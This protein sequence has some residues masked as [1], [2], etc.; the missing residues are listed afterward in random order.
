[1]LFWGMAKSSYGVSHN[2]TKQKNG[3]KI[4]Y[5][6]IHSGPLR[7]VY[8]HRLVAEALLRRRLKDNETVDHEDQ[9]SL[10]PDPPNIQV[11]S[12]KDHGK[13][14]R[15]REGRRKQKKLEGVEG[16]D[17]EIIFRGRDVFNER[18]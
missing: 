6:R 13:L 10:N 11:L 1:M 9:N 15:W 18:A 16:V 2:T 3:K 4:K 17:F 14:T 8:V 12:W 5:L 7:D